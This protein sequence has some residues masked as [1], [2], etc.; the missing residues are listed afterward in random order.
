MAFF[1]PATAGP[2]P[3]PARP[4][5]ILS[6]AEAARQQAARRERIAIARDSTGRLLGRLGAERPVFFATRRRPPLSCA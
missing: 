4:D 1:F 3:A 6:A 5:L 2:S